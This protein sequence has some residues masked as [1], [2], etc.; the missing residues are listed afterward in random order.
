MALR[1]AEEAGLTDVGRQRQTNEDRFYEAAPL[2]AVADGMGGARSGEV[3][4]QI[5]VDEFASNDSDEAKP[6]ERLAGI[7]HEA[8]RKI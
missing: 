8:N 2:F 6:E 3:A 7:A 5:A 1:I 4:S